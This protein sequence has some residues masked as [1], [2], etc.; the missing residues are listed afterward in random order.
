MSPGSAK[1]LNHGPGVSKKS[2][3]RAQ[4]DRGEAVAVAEREG[5]AGL[6]EP[7]K[8]GERC[9]KG[10]AAEHAPDSPEL[11]RAVYAPLPADEQAPDPR[12]ARYSWCSRAWGS[13]GPS[14]R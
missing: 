13:K 12:C 14:S 9:A 3:T 2:K 4:G 6:A 10:G 11:L 1:S 8:P 5:G 7:T